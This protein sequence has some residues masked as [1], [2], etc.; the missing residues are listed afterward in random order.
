MSYRS[1]ADK[2]KMLRPS[3]IV[4]NPMVSHVTRTPEESSNTPSVITA[5]TSSQRE[6]PESDETG[7]S[8]QLAP[9]KRSRKGPAPKLFG[10]ERCTICDSKA[11]GF[12]YNVLS[13][14]GC[15]VC[16]IITVIT[17]YGGWGLL[18]DRF[19]M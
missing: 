15:K 7:D 2:T 13:C 6:N 11:T 14:E 8:A 16:K 9:Q 17:L 5:N 4:R 10:T 19:Y 1:G 18:L 3:V 12:H